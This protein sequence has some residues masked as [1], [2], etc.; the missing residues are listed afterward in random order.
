MVDFTVIRVINFRVRIYSFP[1]Y[2]LLFKNFPDR[3]D[4]RRRPF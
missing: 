3:H 2:N 4:R 1:R